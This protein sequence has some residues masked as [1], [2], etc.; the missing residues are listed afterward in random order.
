MIN[1]TTVRKGDETIEMKKTIIFPALLLMLCGCSTNANNNTNDIAETKTYLYSYDYETE[2]NG[3][4]STAY[5]EEKPSVNE[6]ESLKEYEP[7]VKFENKAGLNFIKMNET[8]TSGSLECTVL[9]AYS[10][11][12]KQF[13]AD[14]FG[15]ECS[16]LLLNHINKYRYV[17]DENG[18]LFNEGHRFF[19]VRM[20]LKY[21]G[22]TTAKISISSPIICKYPDGTYY[23]LGELFYTDKGL[24]QNDTCD[25]TLNPGDEFDSWFFYQA[26]RY[27]YDKTYYLR[28]SFQ[29]N[30]NDESYTGYLVELN[31]IEDVE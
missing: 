17:Y 10:T 15:E 16:Q 23:N 4:L 22:K 25:M 12:S 1:F 7:I 14:T 27:S 24:L 13:A 19:L 29:N 28:G 6:N 8:Y 5:H 31:E 3:E 20:H 26:F 18:N 2:S 11:V 9:K 21:L 30:I